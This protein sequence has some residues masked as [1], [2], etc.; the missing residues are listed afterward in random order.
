MCTV[1]EQRHR[2]IGQCILCTPTRIGRNRHRGQAIDTFTREPNASRL[3]VKMRTY[4]HD[5]T[6]LA[7]MSRAAAITCSQLSSMSSSLRVFRYATTVFEGD[8]VVEGICRVLKIVLA[9][10]VWS[11]SGAR[12][13]RHTPSGVLSSNSLPSCTAKRVLPAPPAQTTVTSRCSC[14]RAVTTPISSCR[15]TNEVT[16]CGRLCREVVCVSRRT[17][18]NNDGFSASA[19]AATATIRKRLLCPGAKGGGT[20]EMRS[21]IRRGVALGGTGLA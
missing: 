18:L 13:T 15:P 3:V 20:P 12:S 7:T 14:R 19:A 2:S 17:I 8:S 16:G 1:N 11:V 9:T 21:R 4:G 5:K 6:I 10:S